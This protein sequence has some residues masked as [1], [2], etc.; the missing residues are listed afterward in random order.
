MQRHHKSIYQVHE[1]AVVYFDAVWR[2]GSIRAAA[3]KLN[4]SS[5]AVNRQILKL[6]A[7]LGTPL[8]DRVVGGMKLTAGG[9]LFARH[10]ST[11]LQDFDRAASEID[12]L[13][14][15]RRGHVEIATVE[16]LCTDLLPQAIAR[17][18]ARHKG[19]TFGV[20]IYGIPEIPAAVID[21]AVHMGI[22]FEVPRRVELR[23]LAGG[24]FRVGAIMRSDHPLASRRRIGLRACA[25]YPL[26][27][28]K[29]NLAMRAQL[30]P[31]LAALQLDERLAV[32]AAS[33]EIMK[34]LVLRDQGIAFQTRVGL[35]SELREGK[36]V[37][38]PLDEG[39]PIG[40]YLGI[41]VTAKNPPPIAAAVFAQMVAEEISRREAK[42]P[43]QKA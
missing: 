23:Q 4:V 32:E 10:T 14:G 6:E 41:Y 20:G 12:A 19:I 11:V 33:L 35:E 26:I 18:R 3:R 43:R 28:A 17:M 5:S 16:G 2:L 36:L 9:E 31:L 27:V 25:D 21:G 1:A 30:E 7:A 38:V 8:F 39:S 22:A 37:H 24:K 34:Q 40:Q 13:S 42:E 15:L 29:S